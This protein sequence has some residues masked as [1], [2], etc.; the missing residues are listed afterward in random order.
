MGGKETSKGIFSIY[1]K[2]TQSADDR[3]ISSLFSVGF[4][5][6][7]TYKTTHSK[8]TQIFIC[9]WLQNQF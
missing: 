8:A 4:F 6:S 7:Y 1:D 3:Y 5:V 2:A 9:T